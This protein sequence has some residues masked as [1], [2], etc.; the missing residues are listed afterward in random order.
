MCPALAALPLIVRR[1]S[2]PDRVIRVAYT[3]LRP[4]RVA[5]TG[6]RPIRVAYT[7]LR[8]LLVAAP[9]PFDRRSDPAGVSGLGPPVRAAV[10]GS[11]AMSRP[12]SQARR[13]VLAFL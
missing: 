12:G 5:Y 1:S 13:P 9:R 2:E 6:L 4:I 11:A 8:P 7:G 10:V 3:G